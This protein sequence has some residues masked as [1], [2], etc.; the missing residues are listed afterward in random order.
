LTK[1]HGGHLQV[2]ST[3]G[4]G[5]TFTLWLPVNI[6]RLLHSSAPVPAPADGTGPGMLSPLAT[7]PAEARA[8]ILFM[9]DD[10]GIRAVV[11]RSLT[12]SGYDVYCT[13]DGREAIEA[14]RKARE[15]GAPFDL[16]L[17]DLDVRG[18]MGGKECIAR[19]KAEFPSLKALL[20]TGYIDD[21]LMETYRDHGFLGVI[22]KPFQLDRLVL[23]LNRLLGTH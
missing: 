11:Q 1:A 19:L 17:V 21:E 15:F 22:P 14:Y 12:Y 10:A 8:R 23:S 7:K 9:D 16:A 6:R 4:Q 3:P 13:R 18:G 5:T 2:E 20:T